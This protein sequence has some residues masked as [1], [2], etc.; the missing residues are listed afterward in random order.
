VIDPAGPRHLGALSRAVTNAGAVGEFARSTCREL[1][2]SLLDA[3]H[4]LHPLFDAFR[5]LGLLAAHSTPCFSRRSGLIAIGVAVSH[6]PR[7]FALG[8]VIAIASR[9]CGRVADGLGVLLRR[10]AHSVYQSR[11]AA[12]VLVAIVMT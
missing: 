1:G 3:A 7:A 9:W 10:A 5:D 8:P 12:V 11:A 2:D 4:R 6:P